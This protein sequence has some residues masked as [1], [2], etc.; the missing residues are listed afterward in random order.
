VIN[1]VCFLKT[2]P[3]EHIPYL[4]S[5]T[6]LTVYLSAYEGFGLPLLVYNGIKLAKNNKMV[7]TL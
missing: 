2:V 7:A 1:D 4:Y 3:F 5:G 6:D